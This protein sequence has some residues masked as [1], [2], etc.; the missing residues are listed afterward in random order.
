VA[1]ETV[2]VSNQGKEQLSRLKKFS[3]LQNWNVL[4]RWAL[5]RSLAEPTIPP[6]IEFKGD[7]GVEISWKVFAG[8]Y[9]NLYLSL[10]KQRCVGD[11]LPTDEGTVSKQFRLHL[12][13]GLGYLASE[14]KIKAPLARGRRSARGLLELA[15]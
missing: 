15:R 9:Q 4:C 8:S 11:G 12:H 3:G 5:C 13:R 7:D 6:P 14:K 10:V 2:K 1:I